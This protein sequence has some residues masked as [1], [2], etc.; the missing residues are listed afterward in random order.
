ML[1]GYE[2]VDWQD[3]LVSGWGTLAI[4]GAYPD[5]LQWVKVPPVSDATCNQPSSY[6]GAVTA[7]MICAGK[8][9][10]RHHAHVRDKLTFNML[11]ACQREV[12]I[13]ARGTVVDLW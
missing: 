9:T 13:A 10:S 6:N 11:K 8:A 4:G 1:E 7:N 5:T 12:L 3:T 2:Y